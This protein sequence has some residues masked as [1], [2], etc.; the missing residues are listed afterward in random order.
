M[1]AET[2]LAVYD[3]LMA[4]TG[5]YR[6]R[7]ELAVGGDSPLLASLIPSDEGLTIFAC[8]VLR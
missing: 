5:V 2:G 7:H 1:N 8:E 4:D 3:T 6:P